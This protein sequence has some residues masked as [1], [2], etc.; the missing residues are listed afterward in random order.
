M[1]F[2]CYFIRGFGKIAEM[3]ILQTIRK[4]TGKNEWCTPLEIQPTILTLL[5]QLRSLYNT[6]IINIKLWRTSPLSNWIPLKSPVFAKTWS[7]SSLQVSNS[8]EKFVNSYQPGGTLTAVVGDWTSR[9]ID[10]GGDPYG[11]GHWSSITLRTSVS[12]RRSVGSC[13]SPLLGSTH[14]PISDA[15]RLKILIISTV[16]R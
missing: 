4:K 2:Q 3:D 6:V 9:I 12:A 14:Y 8:S 7:H 10:R 16:T 13:V 5:L 15:G 11:M 1:P